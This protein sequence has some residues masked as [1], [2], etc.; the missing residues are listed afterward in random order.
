MAKP[1]AVTAVVV[2]YNGGQDLH[3]CLQSLLAQTLTDLQILVVDNA[4]TDGSIGR[5]ES[6]FNGRIRVIRRPVNGGYAAG[7]NTGWYA[8]RTPIV[9]ILNQ[10]LRLERECLVRMRDALLLAPRQALV[11][12]KLV[13]RVDPNRVNSIGNDVHLSGVGWC[14]G[15]GTR[16]RDWSGVTEVTAISGAAFMTTRAFLERL[17]GLEEGYFMYMEDVDLS[18][19]ARLEGAA[20]LAACDAVAAHG[21]SMALTPEKFG[22]LERNRRAFWNRF[23]GPARGR[24]LVLLQVEAMGWLYAILRSPS[25]VAAKW[26]AQ[27]SPATLAGPDFPGAAVIPWLSRRHPYE[28]LFPDSKLVSLVGKAVDALVIRVL[29]VLGGPEQSGPLQRRS[30]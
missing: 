7:A 18:V 27:R 2:A 5:I 12:P 8:A 24:W 17:C 6:D 1:A 21:A 9:A 19:R 3:D 15:L 22:L 20:C 10:D 13:M 23:V 28:I 4:S 14:H 16:S 11:T 29:R 30:R 25:Y 26:A